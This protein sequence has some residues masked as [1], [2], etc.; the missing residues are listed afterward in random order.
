MSVLD[1]KQDEYGLRRKLTPLNTRA[2]SRAPRD[3]R[4]NAFRIVPQRQQHFDFEAG[5]ERYGARSLHERAADADVLEEADYGR[6]R[7]HEDPDRDLQR[8]TPTPTVL[9][10]SLAWF[11]GRRYMQTTRQQ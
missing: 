5:P 7:L 11:C 3:M 8:K 1:T 2:I 9:H 10:H 6:A 4:R